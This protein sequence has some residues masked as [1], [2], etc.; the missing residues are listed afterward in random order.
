MEQILEHLLGEMNATQENMNFNQEKTDANL[1]EMKAA[2]KEMTAQMRAWQKE[3]DR[4]LSG[5]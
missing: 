2:H 4:G 5:K 3:K 1:K